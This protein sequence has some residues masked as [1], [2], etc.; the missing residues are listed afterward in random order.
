MDKGVIICYTRLNYIQS[1]LNL[2]VSNLNEKEGIVEMP[3]Q[4]A[5]S[6][7]V[8]AEAQAAVTAIRE[9]MMVEQLP[10]C[11]RLANQHN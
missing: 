4:Q 5:G 3:E 6:Q 1:G 2:Y 9:Q 11:K 7:Y 10:L 8:A